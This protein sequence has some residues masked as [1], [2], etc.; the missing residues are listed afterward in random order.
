M[1]WLDVILSV[2]LLALVP[3][4]MA[5]YGG[6][7]AAETLTDPHRRRVVKRKFWWACVLGIVIASASQYRTTKADGERQR[8]TEKAQEEARKASKDLNDTEQSVLSKLDEVINNP[9]PQQ[10]K[11]AAVRLKEEIQGQQ[12]AKTHQPKKAERVL[13]FKSSL[14][15]TE[16][17]RKRIE[18]DM[19]GAAAY[20]EGLGIDVPQTIPPIGV[21]TQDPKATGF[22]T[23]YGN[24][25]Y[26]YDKIMLR[27]GMLDND[28]QITEAFV[29]Y[30]VSKFLYKPP[31]LVSFPTT[32]DEAIAANDTPERKEATYK[33]LA[34]MTLIGYLNHSFWGKGFAANQTPVCPDQGTGL[35]AAYFWKVRALYGKSFTDK[36]AAYTLRA[37]AD[38]PYTDS[39]QH[40]KEYFYQRLTTAD[41]VIDNE[42]AKFPGIEA[43]LQSCGW[44]KKQA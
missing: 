9:N 44:L 25:K 37:L 16:A 17:R 5:A 8:K 24:P 36:L 18:S 1:N 12:A 15:F 35:A 43:I 4:G 30:V 10:R 41:S 6:Q 21:E 26:Y 23:N 20:L 28:L 42:S 11:E 39:K 19:N 27:A 34:S 13:M 3:L 29:T 33:W 22:S 14:L 31:Q 40:F 7:I 38:Q 2:V 32:A